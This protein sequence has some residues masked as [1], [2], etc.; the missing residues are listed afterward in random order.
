[1]SVRQ[2]QTSFK[3]HN[4]KFTSIHPEC[5]DLITELAYSVQRYDLVCDTQR[6]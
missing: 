3:T 4:I 2:L 6:R 5:S 1:M